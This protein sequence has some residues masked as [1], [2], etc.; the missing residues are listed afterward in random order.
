M[1][2]D[3]QQLKAEY[4]T[5]RHYPETKAGNCC[6]RILTKSAAIYGGLPYDVEPSYYSAVSLCIEG[7]VMFILSLEYPGTWLEVPDKGKAFEARNFL[8][9]MEKA[10]TGITN[11]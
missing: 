7:E 1:A 8:S 2:L 10:L 6:I 9:S 4:G 5:R 3:I 11:F